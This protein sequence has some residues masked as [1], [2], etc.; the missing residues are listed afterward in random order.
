MP[1]SGGLGPTWDLSRRPNQWAGSPS[2]AHMFHAG[3]QK[4]IKNLSRGF[5]AIIPSIQGPV[6]GPPFRPYALRLEVHGA[7]GSFR[8]YLRGQRAI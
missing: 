5:G 8:P 6:K 3:G 4:T 7:E 1:Y 2:R